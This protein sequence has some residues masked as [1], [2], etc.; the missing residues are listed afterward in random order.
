MY[1]FEDFVAL[2]ESKGKTGSEVGF[3]AF[4]LWLEYTDSQNASDSDAE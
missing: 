1:S 4:W 3:E 2:A